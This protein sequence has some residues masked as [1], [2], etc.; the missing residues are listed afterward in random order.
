MLVLGH[1]LQALGYASVPLFPVYLDAI[2]ATRAEIGTI[3]A[4]AG[5]GGLLFKPLVGWALDAWGRKPTLYVGTAVLTLSMFMLGFV[6]DTGWYVYATRILTGVGI[7]TLFTAYFTA[8]SDVIPNSR[9]TEGIA[10][11]GISG[12]L[13]LVVNPFVDQLHLEPLNL[14][15]VFPALSL[16]V[17]LS[18]VMV[19][20]TPLKKR[21]TTDIE[22]DECKE[23]VSFSQSIRAIFS[24][25]LAP[26][27][28]AT[29]VFAG[30]VGVF[31]SFGTVVAANRGV[32][33]PGVIW[34]SYALGA[35]AVRVIGAKLPDRLGVHNMVA[36]ALAIYVL[37]II[38]AIFADSTLSFGLVGL[39]SGLG[40]GYCFP[41]L[42]SLVVSRSDERYR[43]TA[44]SAFTGLW[45]AAALIL[46]PTMGWLA[47]VRTDETMFA[48]L[49][50]GAVIGLGA[51]A[52]GEWMVGRRG[53][54]LGQT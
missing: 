17:A 41:V 18:G 19:F 35:C 54:R 49:G 2:H 27:W 13:P 51:W 11:F 1:F 36:P 23:P 30:L 45:D 42:T 7:A 32:E 44:L 31:M 53:V 34:L 3:M 6:E 26:V 43:G 52:V 20:L 47:T 24:R 46:T 37:G 48:T 12:L 8:A 25:Q 15:W 33:T 28:L 38:G 9:R 14:R 4:C 39:L 10:L 5:V 16:L 21:Q 29:V 40:H 22:T 50:L